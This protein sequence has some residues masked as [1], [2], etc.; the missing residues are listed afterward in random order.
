MWIRLRDL[1]G[2]GFVHDEQFPSR[3]EECHHPDGAFWEI[4][5]RS[6]CCPPISHLPGLQ[7]GPWV[8]GF[9]LRPVLCSLNTVDGQLTH[10]QCVAVLACDM[11]VL[12]SHVTQDW[13]IFLARHSNASHFK[14]S[15]TP[16]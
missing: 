15:S 7:R 2:Q 6:N 16:V 12:L 1:T 10:F 14:A 4:F 8:P 13:S 3:G 9:H 5:E 11:S